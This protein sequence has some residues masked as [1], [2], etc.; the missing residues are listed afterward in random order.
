MFINF[1]G[2]T[3]IFSLG[4]LL[5]FLLTIKKKT[6]QKITA[7]VVGYLFLAVFIY[8]YNPPQ[9]ISNILR[10]NFILGILSS[11]FLSKELLNLDDYKNVIIEGDNKRP[12]TTFTFNKSI[13]TP[14]AKIGLASAVLFLLL[15]GYQKVASITSIHSR[16]K[17]INIQQVDQTEELKST[18]ETPIALSTMSAKNKMQKMM[19]IV[20]NSNMFSLGTITAQMVNGEYVYVASVEFKDVLKWLKLREVPGY[21]IMS[22][23]D[24][25]AQPKFVKKAM[26]YTP[27]AF[28]W[29]DASR[30]IYSK[31]TKYRNIGS[32][33]LEISDDGTPYYIQTL[34][35]EYGLSGKSYFNQ[36][37]TAV[38]NT[39]TGEVKVYGMNQ[40][41]KFIE[42]T[43]TSAVAQEMNAFYGLYGKGWWNQWMFGSKV[44]V[45]QPTSNGVY[46]H[47]AVTPLVNKD[48]EL[49]YFTDFTSQD[50]SQDSALGYSLIN[51][52]TGEL[53]YYKDTK[54]MMDS[55]GAIKVAEKI[56]PEKKWEARMPILYNVNGTPTWVVT[57]LDSNG[58]FKKYVYLS[59]IDSDIIGD[60]PSAQE[61][62][63]NYRMRL[64]T[65]GKGETDS[66][67][68]ENEI[69]GV[70]K[71]VTVIPGEK[72][73]AVSFILEN[74]Q[75]VY[76]L[77][78]Q[79]DPYGIFLKEGDQ[80]TFK[81]NATKDAK[82]ASAAKVVIDGVTP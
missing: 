74:S 44:G 39:V 42:A 13:L 82:V 11:L 14:V 48:G 50:T 26:R 33:N 38:L 51:A 72:Q 16:Y 20:P 61:A 8:F 55:D 49:F 46:E 45:K 27:S 75:T 31:A 58:I 25:S 59:A 80:V 54:G 66:T 24:V 6:K 21:F 3:F 23:T 43:L 5:P 34:E 69:T 70:V 36:Y 4:W 1:L 65:A 28:L 22:A 60:G 62:L 29:E 15:I 9:N 17:T 35:K 68:L 47:G 67:D 2:I 76:T 12:K 7:M 71:R 30:K 37:K 77:Q 81:T 56:Y 32:V 18:E 10:I 79:Q 64:S 41:P 53:Q 52:R 73:V 57:L 19:S 63:E 40:A 78:S